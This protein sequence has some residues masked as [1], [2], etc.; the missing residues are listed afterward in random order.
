MKIAIANNSVAASAALSEAVL[1]STEH[2][3]IWRAS[4]GAQA[5]RMCA[6]HRPDLLLMDLAMPVIDGVEATR[7][8]MQDSPCAILVVTATPDENSGQ[9]FRAMGAGALDVTATPVLNGQSGDAAALLAKIRTIAKLIQA[10]QPAG[11]RAA[12]AI[13]QTVYGASNPGITM[14]VVIGASTGGPTAIAKVLAG[15][16][17]P[18][19]AAVV[20]VQHIDER[21]ADSFATWLG[22]QIGMP[23]TTIDEG[24]QL[25]T[26]GIFIAKSNDHLVL[27]RQ[28]YLRY[29]AEPL[30]Y[31]YRPSVNVFFDCV[32]QHWHH[33][34]IGTLLTGMGRDGALGLLSL[35]E[36]GKLTIA[37]DKDS[38]VYGMPRAA[39]EL[40]AAI[41]ILPLEEI[42]A[43]LQAALDFGPASGIKAGPASLGRANNGQVLSITKTHR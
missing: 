40:G 22:S 39:A 29:S 31:P 5:I 16:V 32:A 7:T 12:T 42:G 14:L 33:E 23:V 10:D 19:H 37:Q 11:R 41:A 8:I 24:L 43:A 1:A 34:A 35:K 30:D 20:I 21:F 36:T 9:V 13:T 28:Q 17:L 4:D 18:S 15:L 27:D 6:Q 3:I 38:A 2:Q 25:K 26:S